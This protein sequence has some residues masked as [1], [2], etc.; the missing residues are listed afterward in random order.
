MCVLDD[1]T[2]EMLVLVRQLACL[3]DALLIVAVAFDVRIVVLL[4]IG[5]AL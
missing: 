2:F 3:S 1:R 5:S 4:G